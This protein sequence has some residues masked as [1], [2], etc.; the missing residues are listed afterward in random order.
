MPRRSMTAL[1]LAAAALSVPIAAQ[2][3]TAPV[4]VVA[5]LNGAMPTGV[6]V[7]PNGRIFLNYPQWGDNPPFAV[8]ELKGGKPVAYP[9]AASNDSGQGETRDHF[10]SVQ[11]VVADGANRLW[12][13]DTGAPGFSAPVPGGAKLVAID[14]ATN[15]VVK[16]LVLDQPDVVLQTTYLNDVRFD[17][18]Q[19]AEG[20]AYITDSSIKGPGGLI[21]VDIATGKAVRRLSGHPS[22]L[23]DPGFTPTI[24]GQ[25]LMNRPAGGTPSPWLV[26]TDGIAISPDG[27]TLYYCALSSRHFYSV[28]TAL[29]R[30]P[31]A[32][33][34]QIAAAIRDLGPKAPSDG[35]AEDAK[36]N[37]Y[38]GDYEH[39][40]IRRFSGGKWQTIAQDPKILW[41]DTLSV[42]KDGWL[43][44]TANQL[45]RQAGF[46][47]GRDLRK[48]PY[49]LLRVRI[50]AGPVLLK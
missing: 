38:A 25:V 42:S 24:E 15:R 32:T 30:D 29:L 7:A 35:L 11:S 17:L 28:P 44:F 37:V 19:G 34:A 27:T 23:P 41:P 4:E 39:G 43:Y 8:A 1:A 22:T 47:E 6:T 3:K 13:L 31:A 2:Q 21:V 16:T 49:Q 46:H 40:T 36:G 14:L 33:D 20:V 48:Q 10:V 5:D 45:Q 12:V 18:R 9:D 50:G 26:A